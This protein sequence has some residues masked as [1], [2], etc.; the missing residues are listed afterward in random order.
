MRLEAM[1]S[2]K[3]RK[4]LRSEILLQSPWLKTLFPEMPLLERD[5]TAME[6]FATAKTPTMLV[7]MTAVFLQS[8]EGR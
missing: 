7:F 4:V 8:S 1:L 2:S 6:K 3:C 5:Q